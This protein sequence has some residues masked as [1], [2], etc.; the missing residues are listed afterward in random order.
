MV[1]DG[2]G[3]G[4]G[5]ALVG[6]GKVGVKARWEVVRWGKGTVGGGEEE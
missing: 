3:G 6:G 1:G 4:W 5:E 2:G